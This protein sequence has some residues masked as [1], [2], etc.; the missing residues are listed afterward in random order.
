[1]LRS[2]FGIELLDIVAGF[3]QDLKIANN[4]ILYQLI[5]RNAT[6]SSGSV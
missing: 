1:M 5:F 2:E 3:A 6:S 4:R